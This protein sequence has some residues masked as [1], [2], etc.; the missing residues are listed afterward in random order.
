MGWNEGY[1]G[2]E[3]E[4]EAEN[5][6]SDLIPKPSTVEEGIEDPNPEKEVRKEAAAG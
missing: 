2:F 1:R 6:E 4:M 5:R 3:A